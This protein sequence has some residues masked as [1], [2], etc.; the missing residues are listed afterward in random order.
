MP[1]AT[2][3]WWACKRLARARPSCAWH[4]TATARWCAMPPLGARSWQVTCAPSSA[5]PSGPCTAWL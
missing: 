2:L 4:S 1:G 5:M 3:Q